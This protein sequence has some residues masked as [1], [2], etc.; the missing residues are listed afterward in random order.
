MKKTVLLSATL[1]A[2][3]ALVFAQSFGF[4][5]FN[6]SSSKGTS[7]ITK[8]EAEEKIN[9]KTV[10]TWSFEGKVTTAYQYGYVGVSIEPQDDAI[11]QALHKGK[12]IRFKVLGDGNRYRFKVETPGG[13]DNHYGKDFAT[14]KNKETVITIEY[15]SLAQEPYWGEKKAFVPGEITKLMIQTVGQPISSYKFKVYDFEVVN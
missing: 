4:F 11:L 9:G 8:T 2:L 15:K 10:S 1:L 7:T 5:E 3:G 6:D 13:A 12:G 14:S